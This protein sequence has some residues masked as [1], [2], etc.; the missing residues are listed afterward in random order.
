MEYKMESS[1]IV[2]AS[3]QTPTDRRIR[4]TRAALK[5]SLTT[6]MQQ[7]QIKDISVRELTELADV[8]RGTFYL[9]YKDVFD[10]LEQSEADLLNE[11][12]DTINSYDAAHV[13]ENSTFLF[14]GVYNLCKQNADL[15]RILIGENGDIKFLNK[16]K[17]LVKSK[18]LEEWSFITNQQNPRDFD[19]YYAFIVGGC[20][21]L[22]QNWF[23]SGMIQSPHELAELTR[24]ILS[25]GL[26]M[27]RQ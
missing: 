10:L 5:K 21:S 2:S 24:K 15:V 6:L 16:L 22:L 11:F 23:S 8:N 9:H 7:K 1:T 12:H 27:T 25:G 20:I 4:K 19:S 17:D 3:E 26:S 13:S 18:C 14:E